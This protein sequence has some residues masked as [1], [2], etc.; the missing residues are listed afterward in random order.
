[1]SAVQQLVYVEKY[2][3]PRKGKLKTLSDVYMAILWPSAIGQPDTHVLFRE[4]DPKHPKRYIQNAKLD[5]NDDGCIT[6][7][8][9]TRKVTR[10][11]GVGMQDGNAA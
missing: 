11:L 9:A 3:R 8:E 5:W 1:M 4:S 10:L 7:A 2:F 6:K